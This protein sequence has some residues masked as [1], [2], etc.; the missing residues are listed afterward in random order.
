MRKIRTK[1]TYAPITTDRGI[2]IFWGGRRSRESQTCCFP[3]T[4]D[5]EVTGNWK[6]EEKEKNHKEGDKDV[7][8][9]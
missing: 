8:P 2:R 1:Y 4:R 7:S 6:S 5:F 3:G 9:Q